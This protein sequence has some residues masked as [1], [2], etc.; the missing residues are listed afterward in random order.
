MTAKAIDLTRRMLTTLLVLGLIGDILLW[1]AI[2]AT[3]HRIPVDT[4]LFFAAMTI[5]LIISIILTRKY[6]RV[7]TA[8]TDFD[9]APK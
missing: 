1:L 9:S 7:K 6:I 5:G 4:E 2:H 3:G 8:A